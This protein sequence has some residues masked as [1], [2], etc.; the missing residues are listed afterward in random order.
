MCW[1]ESAE[2]SGYDVDVVVLLLWCWDLQLHLAGLSWVLYVS[3]VWHRH[4]QAQNEADARRA[5]AQAPGARALR[6]RPRF[7]LSRDMAD[8]HLSGLTSRS[9]TSH[10]VTG[11]VSLSGVWTLVLWSLV[12]GESEY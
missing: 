9:D 5:T 1:G 6:P 7:L 10:D 11:D 4:K 2:G 12:R 8:A 3:R